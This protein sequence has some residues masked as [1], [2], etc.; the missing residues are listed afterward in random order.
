MTSENL[1]PKPGEAQALEVLETV[2]GLHI[3]PHDKEGGPP[4]LYDFKVGDQVAV[5]V[6]ILTV[7]DVE[8]NLEA[9]TSLVGEHPAGSLADSWTV[10][11][12]GSA[13]AKR[14]KTSIVDLILQELEILQEVGVSDLRSASCYSLPRSMHRTNCPIARLM[15]LRVHS[16][17]RVSGDPYGPRLLFSSIRPLEVERPMDLVEAIEYEFAAKLDLYKKLAVSSR[18]E[19]HVFFLVRPSRYNS[20]RALMRDELPQRDPIV[21]TGITGVWVAMFGHSEPV[22]FW[23]TSHGWSHASNISRS[24]A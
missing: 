24:G 23:N 6:T 2:T 10:F 5:E 19:K 20:F 4:G 13:K 8:K 3:E 21:P 18:P 15:G 1:K 16:A 12:D 9:F 7:R 22:F 17:S 14:K 11:V